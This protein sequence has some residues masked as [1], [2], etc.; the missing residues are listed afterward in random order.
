MITKKEVFEI[1][2]IPNGGDKIEI[3]AEIHLVEEGR[4]TVTW[5]RDYGTP[6][7]G[8]HE[9]TVIA[10]GLRDLVK[11]KKGQMEIPGTEE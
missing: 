3:L 8:L 6:K 7:F 2:H 5:K 4:Y 11:E 10:D 1:K 9:L